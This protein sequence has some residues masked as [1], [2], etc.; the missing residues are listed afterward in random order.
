MADVDRSKISSFPFNVPPGQNISQVLQ[1]A[2]TAVIVS[3]FS[4][5]YIYFPDGLTFC[6]PWTSGAVLPLSHAVGARA[7]WDSSPFGSQT[8][9]TP[10]AGVTYSAQ[11]QFTNDPNL[12]PA[13]GSIIQNPYNPA[14]IYASTVLG[15]PAG[16]YFSN[17]P[18]T[19]ITLKGIQISAGA[20]AAA[21]ILGEVRVAI[22]DSRS[23]GIYVASL[24]I[25]NTVPS[26]TY[27]SFN[28]ELTFPLLDPNDSPWRV[29]TDL[30]TRVGAGATYYAIS[31]LYYR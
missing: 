14:N 3:N 18:Q 20:T 24:Y 2:P 29:E 17:L 10:P 27:L 9:A 25:T 23:P 15:V 28:D 30:Q 12:L 21:A 5:Y 19:D 8:I 26:E 16:T 6:P 13:G 31:T 4:P 1:F 22:T 11:M 7:N